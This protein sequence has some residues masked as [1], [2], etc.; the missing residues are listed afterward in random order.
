VKKQKTELKLSWW[1]SPQDYNE[2]IQI[3]R[4]YLSDADLQAGLADT[5]A[6]GLPRPVSGAFA[7]VYRMHCPDKDFALK[8]FLASIRDVDARYA[9]ISEFV[10]HDDLPYT[11]TFDYLKNGIKIRGDWF[12]GLKMEWVDG[13]QFDDYIVE[14]LANPKKLGELTDKFVAMM[15]ELRNAGIAHGD[16]QH[17]NIMICKDEIRLV[18]YDGMF[19]PKMEGYEANELGHRNYQHPLRSAKHFGPYL[20]NFSAWLIYTSLRAL[21]IDP[22]F[23]HQLGGGDDCLLFKQ[24]DFADPLHSP[25]FSAL[26]RH[27][28]DELRMLGRFVRAQLK[29]DPTV[30]PCLQLPVPT[31]QGLELELISEAATGVRSGPKLIRGTLPDWL[32]DRLPV[33][34]SGLPVS[35]TSSLAA[36]DPKVPV[37][38]SVVANL[39][40]QN[41]II[42]GTLTP[43]AANSNMAGANSFEPGLYSTPIGGNSFVPRLIPNPADPNSFI[44]APS[45]PHTPGQQPQTA[46][47]TKH[48][49]AGLLQ[50][51]PRRVQF[52]RR[53]G[54]WNPS[55]LQL[56]MLVNPLVWLMFMFGFRSAVQNSQ[57]NY[58]PSKDNVGTVIQVD[59]F[60]D[61][62]PH[63]VV[64]L[65][66]KVN[67]VSFLSQRDLGD[68]GRKYKIGDHCISLPV[69]PKV[70]APACTETKTPEIVTRGA[71]WTLPEYRLKIKR[72]GL[73]SFALLFCLNFI[74]ELLIWIPALAQLNQARY[75][76]PV[77]GTVE[78]LIADGDVSTG[79]AFYALVSYQVSGRS[80]R[81]KIAVSESEY[82]ALTRGSTEIMLCS[83][84]HPREVMF[85]R[86]C[87]YRPA[88]GP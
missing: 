69:N 32:Q 17:G 40:G 58:S 47:V 43:N 12:P 3:P 67:G 59:R 63:T 25:A 74:C 52:N 57:V 24:Q 9:L 7:S 34:N 60:Q 56:L 2:A 73:F 42:S 68:D 79:R 16:L 76:L 87:R 48:F 5:D 88:I 31:L 23:L 62:E 33:A 18:D 15:A 27:A 61:D 4:A 39:L 65:E 8:L 86:F 70:K 55:H 30:I 21:Q 1:P 50:P 19:V 6:L 44:A 64:T 83:Q 53:S 29:N 11:V 51:G 46:P 41:F 66:H 71:D 80:L 10:Q 49:P 85:Y 84:K 38:H 77:W 78:N 45:N 28:S 72:E 75:G 82:R 20:D 14:N 36:D 81:Q 13:V 35:T 26:E 22:R 37:S 54:R